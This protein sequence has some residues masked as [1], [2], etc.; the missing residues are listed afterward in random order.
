M[1]RVVYRLW[2][3]LHC[4]FENG[5]RIAAL[6]PLNLKVVVCLFFPFFQLPGV[7]LKLA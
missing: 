5:D 1:Q 2:L 4:G 3:K 7:F 6:C